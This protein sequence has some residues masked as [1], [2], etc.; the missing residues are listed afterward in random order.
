MGTKFKKEKLIVE[1]CDLNQIIGFYVVIN[2]LLSKVLPQ[3][4]FTCLS[5]IGY[6]V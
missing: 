5:L 6:D 2:I 3:F 4:Q 1:T